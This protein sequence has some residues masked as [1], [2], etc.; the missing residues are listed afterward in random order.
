VSLDPRQA[1]KAGAPPIRAWRVAD[2]TAI[3][4]QLVFD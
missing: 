3:E 1:D 4:V 2:G